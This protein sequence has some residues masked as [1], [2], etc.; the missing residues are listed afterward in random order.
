M[1]VTDPPLPVELDTNRQTLKLTRQATI[2]RTLCEIASSSTDPVT[3]RSTVYSDHDY[4]D[5]DYV[6]YS[7]LSENGNGELVFCQSKL[8]ISLVQVISFTANCRTDKHVD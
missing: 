5:P 4:E 3:N 8:L 1:T 6:S 2:R 7:A